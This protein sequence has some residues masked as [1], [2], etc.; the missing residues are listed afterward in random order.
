MSSPHIP[1]KILIIYNLSFHFVIF[2]IHLHIHS[3]PY[4]EII[5]VLNRFHYNIIKKRFGEKSH[6]L[7][8]DTDSLMYEIEIRISTR[9]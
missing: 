3:H 2:S 4:N 7:F 9:T 5:I 8:T 6:L 1:Y